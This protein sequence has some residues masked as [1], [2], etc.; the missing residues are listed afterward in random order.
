[1]KAGIV[2]EK[3]SSDWGA[4]ADS[5]WLS[6]YFHG[7]ATKEEYARILPVFRKVSAKDIVN[8]IPSIPYNA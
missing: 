1:M 3:Y 8:F 7:M 6:N 2:A 5:L 4:F